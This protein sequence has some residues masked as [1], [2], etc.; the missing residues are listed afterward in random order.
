MNRHP[1]FAIAA[2]VLLIILPALACAAPMQYQAPAPAGEMAAEAEQSAPVQALPPPA[3]PPLATMPADSNATPVATPDTM[4]LEDYGVNP[5]IDT[6]DDTLST[7]AL[8]VDTGSY[9]LVRNYVN[10]GIYPPKEAVRVEEFVNYFDYE[11][12]QPEGRQAFAIHLDGA[13]SP[14]GETERYEIVRVGIQGY[15]VPPEERSDVALTFVIDISGSMDREDR[16]T[17]VKR[18]LT[19]LVEQLRP[20]DQ[21]AIVVYGDTAYTALPPTAVEQRNTILDAIYDLQPDGSTNAEAGLRVGYEVASDGYKPEATNRVILLSDGVANVGETGPAAIL[22]TIEASAEEGIFL[23]TVGFGMGNYNDVLMEQLADRG[24][25]AYAYVDDIDEARRLFVDNLT[26]TLLTIAKDA[27]VQVEFNPE[28]VA[29]YRLIGFENRAL[30][31]EEFRDNQVDAGEIGAGHSVTALYEIKRHEDAPAGPLATVYMRWQDPETGEV[32]EINKALESSELAGSFTDADPGLQLA[33][34]VSEYA[35]VLR[36]SF[37]AQESTLAGVQ[38]EATRVGR[39][40]GGNAAVAEFV[41]LVRAATA[42][43]KP[44]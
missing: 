28:V 18:A 36:E 16:L 6:E 21:V 3:M 5:F 9:S 31:D 23:T 13:P 24:D 41:E 25:G 22:E 11:Y 17:L 37:W 42:L 15:E 14:F 2:L 38:E 8:D 19:Q 26:G 10:Q 29:R 4:I 27:K 30:K 44:E 39:L 40:F 33:L 7:F 43:P 35:E 12:P 20:T 32:I 1:R 34:I